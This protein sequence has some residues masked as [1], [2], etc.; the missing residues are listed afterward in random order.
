MSIYDY[1][2]AK[3]VVVCG[4]IHGD[5]HALVHKLC[6]QYGMKDTLLIVAG[7]CGFGFE[8]PTYYDLTYSKDAGRLRKANNWIAFVRGNHDN[9]AY[10]NEERIVYKRWRTIPDYSVITACGHSILCIGG[11]VSIDRQIRINEQE[12]YDLTETG[13]Y[14]PDE[15]PFFSPEAID[16][17]PIQVNSATRV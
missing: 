2:D 10:F 12:R 1:P 5:F 11:A 6:V 13:Y 8:K 7:D 4:D 14:W 17:T 3:S 16:E 15:A 9:P